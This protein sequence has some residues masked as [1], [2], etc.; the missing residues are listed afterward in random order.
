MEWWAVDAEIV[1]MSSMSD[2]VPTYDGCVSSSST[3]F[4][5]TSNDQLGVDGMRMAVRLRSVRSIA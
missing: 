1:A 5:Q 4:H 3:S 2:G